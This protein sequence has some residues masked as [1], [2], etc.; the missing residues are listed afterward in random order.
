MI[1]KE[2]YHTSYEGFI[3]LLKLF[4]MEDLKSI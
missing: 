2:I 4:K 3:L 1:Y